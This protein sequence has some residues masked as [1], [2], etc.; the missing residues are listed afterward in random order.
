[1]RI[2]TG[3]NQRSCS[4]LVEHRIARLLARLPGR[5]APRYR[6]AI[7]SVAVA[8]SARLKGM[9]GL[10]QGGGACAVRLM[11]YKDEYEWTGFMRIPNSA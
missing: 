10:A 9:T 1:M 3:A 4:A 8:E 2:L 5:R 7:Q 6:A 11:A